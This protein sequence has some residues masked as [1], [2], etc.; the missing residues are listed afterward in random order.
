MTVA[1]LAVK[2]KGKDGNY[3]ELKSIEVQGTQVDLARRSVQVAKVHVAGGRRARLARRRRLD[4]SHGAHGRTPACGDRLHAAV[5]R[6]ERGDPG[7]R[8]SRAGSCASRRPCIPIG[9][10]RFRP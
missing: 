4:Q 1:D 6:S 8:H 5:E 2:P 7:C 9:L 10:D 3:I